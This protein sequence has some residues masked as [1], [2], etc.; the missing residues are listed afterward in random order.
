MAPGVTAS[1]SDAVGEMGKSAINIAETLARLSAS[2]IFELRDEWRRLHRRPPPMRL[3]RDLL[4]RG[5]EQ[6]IFAF[7]RPEQG[8]FE[9]RRPVGPLNI[10]NFQG[11]CHGD[12]GLRPRCRFLSQGDEQNQL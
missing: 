11:H 4:I 9:A 10:Y 12:Q 8:R 1:K 5:N 7:W 6:G 3:S 2:S